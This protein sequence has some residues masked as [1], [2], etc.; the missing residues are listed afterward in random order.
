[1]SQHQRVTFEQGREVVEHGIRHLSRI[2]D[3]LDDLSAGD[4]P[5]RLRMLLETVE[6]E[7]RNLLGALQRW[8][9]DA[10]DKVLQTYAQ[11]TVELPAE[12]A[13][14]AEPLTNLGL[15]QWLG[16]ENGYL[17]QTFA[18]LAANADDRE[19]A[20]MFRGIAEQIEAHE[21]TLSKQYQRTED[22]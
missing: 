8:L 16:Q 3:V 9:D 14:P 13:P 10:P 5:E 6:V 1:M 7:Q 17:Q 20:R 21:R 19:V 15:T 22:L 2:R 11:Y 18:E 12:V 4:N